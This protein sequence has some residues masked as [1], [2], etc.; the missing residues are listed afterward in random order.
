MNGL[1][2]QDRLEP[3]GI[4]LGAF[5]VLVAIGTASGMPWTTLN[6]TGAAALQIIGILVLAAL[7]VGLAVL[8]YEQ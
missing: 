1:D 4:A 2:F 5:L 7:G 8:S 3:V 6:S